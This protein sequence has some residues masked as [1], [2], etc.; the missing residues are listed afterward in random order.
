MVK[1]NQHQTNTIPAQ[2]G[3]EIEMTEYEQERKKLERAIIDLTG[4]LMGALEN[5]RDAVE[6]RRAIEEKM[7]GLLKKLDFFIRKTTG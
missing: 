7:A 5:E 2:A 3:E 6:S 4:K 1:V